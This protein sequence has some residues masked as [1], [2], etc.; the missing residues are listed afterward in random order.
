MI[1][2]K[3]KGRFTLDWWGHHGV[4][5]WAR[6]RSNGRTIARYVP[7]IDLAVLDWFAVLHDAWRQDEG[8]DPHHGFRAMAYV[9][10][11][12]EGDQLGLTTPQFCQLLKALEYHNVQW[13]KRPTD[14]T[15]LACW[16]ADRLD[17]GRV[18]ITP[19]ADLMFAE[20][21]PPTAIWQAMHQRAVAERLKQ[22]K[23]HAQ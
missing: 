7:G 12:H 5:H 2:Q 3:I 22:R 14:I 10:K 11:I 9:R 8:E 17:L 21:L 4:R 16:N 1:L 23:F 13:V 18:G 6:V 20:A 19:R 15:V